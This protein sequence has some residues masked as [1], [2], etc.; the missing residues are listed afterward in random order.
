MC[1][2]NDLSRGEGKGSYC[3]SI[4]NVSMSPALHFNPN[5]LNVL[6][7]VLCEYRSNSVFKQYI[8]TLNLE[9]GKKSIHI[10]T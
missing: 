5:G 8:L 6:Q 4:L 2:F 1:F 10:V 7:S 3:D 9:G